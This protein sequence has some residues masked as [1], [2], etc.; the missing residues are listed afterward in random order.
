MSTTLKRHFFSGTAVPIEGDD[1]D[2]DRIIPARFLKE[3][4]FENMG[5]YLF[6]DV[7][8]DS[9]GKPGTH[10]LNDPAFKDASLMVVGNNFGCG[11]SREHAPQAIMRYGIQA[12]IGESFAEI[13]AGNCKAIGMPAVSATPHDIRLLYQYIYDNPRKKIDLNLTTKTVHFGDHTIA[14][15]LPE[16]RRSVFLEGTW[17]ALELLKSNEKRVQETAK[18]LPYMTGFA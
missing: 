13:F 17:N 6:H 8:F 5:N 10:P 15:D 11:S 1:L 4:T 2:T 14:I 9:Q 3:I 7:R 16:S 12:I 18:K